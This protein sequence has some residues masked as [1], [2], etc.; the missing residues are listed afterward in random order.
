[1]RDFL[2]RCAMVAGA[3]YFAVALYGAYRLH[4]SRPVNA[5]SQADEDRCFK[6]GG[7]CP[8]NWGQGQAHGA[9]D[10]PPGTIEL[11][12]EEL[13]LECYRTGHYHD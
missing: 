4:H 6:I 10:C 3:L 12:A 11:R 8:A 9:G 5:L 7:V 2:K 1:M 13:F